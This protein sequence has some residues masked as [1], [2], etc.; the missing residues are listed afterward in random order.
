MTVDPTL[1]ALIREKIPGKRFGVFFSTGEGRFY[2]NGWE[3]CSGSVVT[4]D[5]EHYDYWTGWDADHQCVKLNRWVPYE[6]NGAWSSVREY[7]DARRE[8]GLT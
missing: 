8:A 7:Q 2:E 4:E 1:A 3:E 6:R 5:D